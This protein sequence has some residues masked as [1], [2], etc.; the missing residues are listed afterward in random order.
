MQNRLKIK[1]RQIIIFFKYGI[2][3]SHLKMHYYY[4]KE[5]YMY[6][7]NKLELEKQIIRNKIIKKLKSKYYKKIKLFKNEIEKQKLE[8]NKDKLIWFCWLQGMENAPPL[9]KMNYNTILKNLGDEYR[10]ILIT[11]ENLKD[12]IILP[13]YIIEKFNKGVLSAAHF[14]DIIRNELLIKY[15]GSWID[16]T[17][18]CESID[19]DSKNS[20]LD[21]DFFMFQMLYPFPVVASIENWFITSCK[22]NRNIILV[23]K[24]LL[25]YWKHNNYAVDYLLYY[26]FMEIVKEEYKEDWEHIPIGCNM[27]ALLLQKYLFEEFNE[28]KF[29]QIIKCCCFQKLTHHIKANEANKKDTFYR[30]LLN[31]K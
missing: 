17:I 14:S 26:C 5:N 23:Q 13:D 2:F 1:L 27:D 12:Y 8:H 30:F 18:Y 25:D 9:I 11:N 3:Y 22:N 21:S 29:K 6:Y 19:N 16:A 15:G 24:L 31:R 10:V 4:K 20:F 28:E 7:F